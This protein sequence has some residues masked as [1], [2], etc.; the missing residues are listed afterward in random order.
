MENAQSRQSRL[1]LGQ[2]VPDGALV[3]QAQAGNQHA[4]EVL[5]QR[6]HHHLAGY[7]RFYLTDDDQLADVLQQV[8]LQLYLS[9]P[10]LLTGVLLRAWLL[11]VARSRCLDELR[12]SRAETP[13]SRLERDASE[14]ESSLIETISDPGPLP[15]VVVERG[16][17]L[18]SLRA[19]L[20]ALPP[21]HRLVV[22]L[23]CFRHLTEAL[24]GHLL[25]IREATAK[26]CFYR[27]LSR[28]RKALAVKSA[29]GSRL[30]ERKLTTLQDKQRGTH[31]E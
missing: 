31:H 14:E 17:R 16:E 24:I 3:G 25:N 26:S 21:R 9:L 13:F 19:A 10:T 2:D 29:P 8:Y 1:R 6:Y 12:R 28:L 20:V 30:V 15:E 11:Q 7:I 22:Q 18:W 4:F 27:T 5:V 23:H